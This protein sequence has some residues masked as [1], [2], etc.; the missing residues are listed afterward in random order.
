MLWGHLVFQTVV[1]WTRLPVQWQ[2]FDILVQ[3][4]AD[5]D[6]IWQHERHF[7][8]MTMQVDCDPYDF[9]MG[10]GLTSRFLQAK[11]NATMQYICRDMHALLLHVMTGRSMSNESVNQLNYSSSLELYPKLRFCDDALQVSHV[12]CVAV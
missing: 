10:W 4:H 8:D 2:L 3:C 6:L 11:F 5:I 1:L 12:H 9:C 7:T